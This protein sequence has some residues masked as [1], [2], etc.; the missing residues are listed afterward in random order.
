MFLCD[1]FT[2][3]NC[4]GST[5]TQQILKNTVFKDY[6][7]DTKTR[8][9]KEMILA[10]RLNQLYSKDTILTFYLNEVDFSPTSYGVKTAARYYF[11]KELDQL[12]LG[13]STFLAGLP[14]NWT[15]YSPYNSKQIVCRE[16]QG[17][18][19][20]IGL[21]EGQYSRDEN[22]KVTVAFDGSTV[23]E[24]NPYKCRQLF[25][26]NEFEQE[27]ELLKD[28]GIN[29]PIQDIQSARTEELAFVTPTVEKNAPHFVDYAIGQL[30]DENAIF[31]DDKPLTMSMLNERGY[32]I[33]TTIDL[34]IQN[35]AQKAVFDGAESNKKNYGAYNSS[36]G[37]I[38]SRTG[39]VLA[40]VGSKGYNLESEGKNA[41]TG[42]S[43]F[44]GQVNI[45][46]SLQ[47]PGSSMK[48]I[49]EVAGFENGSLYPSAFIPDVPYK[50]GNYTPQNAFGGG[51]GY[52]AGSTKT[53]ERS[54]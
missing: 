23:I 12:T 26:L 27:Q 48:P 51:V 4:G 43:K 17:D 35:I 9:I 41:N 32:N 46:N 5:I 18:S 45:M 6:P 16:K 7:Y 54:A 52:S 11:N 15:I 25:V 38:D 10:L 3:G 13:E 39:E 53:F 8:K 49:S 22:G 21:S 47:Q 1:I 37:A 20:G 30:I 14:Q 31:I 33:F 29:I 28:H 44:D 36:L 40:M 19:T 2:Q 34:D 24:T 42:I 50:V